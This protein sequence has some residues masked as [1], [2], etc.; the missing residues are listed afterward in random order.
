MNYDIILSQNLSVGNQLTAKPHLSPNRLEI[1]KILS[2]PSHRRLEYLRN[3]PIKRV[4]KNIDNHSSGVYL[5][6]NG[7]VKKQ[8]PNSP[9]GVVLWK[10]EI[11]ALKR[12]YGNPHFPLLLSIDPTH[13]TIYLNY[14]G[15]TLEDNI[16]LP[17][18]WRAQ[19]RHIRKALFR[20]RLNPNDILPRNVCVQNGKIILI[21]FG[22]SNIQSNSIEKSI[23]RLQQLFEN[24]E[25]RNRRYW[26]EV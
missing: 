25:L 17:N 20:Y 14:C 15:K 6:R 1:E 22:L 24:Y 19:I 10:N 9:Q 7:I 4:L 26:K 23:H 11:N 18:K 16:Q 2:L 5:L 12:V 21:D 13:Y 8:L 3:R